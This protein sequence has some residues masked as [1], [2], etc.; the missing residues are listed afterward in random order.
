MNRRAAADSII[1][2]LHELEEYHLSSVS[3][4][5]TELEDSGISAVAVGISRSDIVKKF[6]NDAFVVNISKCLSSCVK[7]PA[8]AEGSS[9]RPFSWFPWLLSESS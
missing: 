8:F 6:C 3:L 1:Y 7:V 2:F 5:G 9:F 4:T